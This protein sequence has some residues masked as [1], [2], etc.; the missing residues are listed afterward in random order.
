M[1]ETPGVH[2][3][4][5]RTED[6]DI[7][8]LSREALD[9]LPFGVITL[10]RSGTIL[11]YN[12]EQERLAH[13][14]SVPSVGLNFF[15][16]VAPCTNVQAFRGRFDAFVQ[17][18][19]AG[20]ERF[21][22]T[23]AFRWGHQ[24]VSITM[25][26]KAGVEEINILVRGR[27]T[28]AV[29]GTDGERLTD[30]D[31]AVAFADTPRILA[32]FGDPKTLP[33]PRTYGL[34]PL[35]AADPQSLG[36]RVHP[37]HVA[38]VG[39]V[40]AHAV[41]DRVPYAVEYRGS[42]GSSRR[43]FQEHGYFGP[44]PGQ[45]GQATIVDVTEQRQFA[46]DVWRA[47][48]YDP[49]TGLPNHKLLLLRI[50]DAV[51]AAAVDGRITAIILV[52]IVD[53]RSVNDTFGHVGGNKLLRAVGLRLGE[54]VR[55]G[56]TVARVTAD[57]FAVLLTD[58]AAPQSVTDVATRM[59]AAA[60]QPFEIDG[61]SHYLTLR[62]GVS[63][64]P[65]DGHDP[66]GLLIAAETAIYA[67]KASGGSE[68]RFYSKQLALDAASSLELQNE[69]RDGLE[70]RQFELAYQ[71]LVDI[72]TGRVVAVE[73]LVRWNHPARG[74]VSPLDFIPLADRSGLI[75]PLG[76]WVLRTACGQAR[77]WA[78]LGIDVRVCVN[79]STVQFARPDFVDL[80]ATV[81]A[82]SSLPAERLE[83]ELTESIMVDGFGEMVETLTRLK[84]LGL[85]LA[86]D[87]F[88]TGYS[89]LSYLKYFPVDTLKID[90]AF[91]KDIVADGFDNA[92]AT[93]I[94]TLS[95][96]LALECVVEGVETA[97]QLEAL[98]AIGCRVVQGFYFS[99][100]LTAAKITARFFGPSGSPLTVV[101]ASIAAT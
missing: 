59:I 74:F 14:H 17:S 49:L 4:D 7:F 8:E 24:D 16:D 93:T 44:Q 80:V 21:T 37:D 84:A 69:L 70:N 86:I 71:P 20:S 79:V 38:A 100:P 5:V 26:R 87:D 99:R 62:A 76:E 13:R 42:A 11:R 15:N 29:P 97:E 54:C 41:R 52:N 63:L 47:A 82:D 18:Y 73:A 75:V 39:L 94:F 55:G 83:L 1:M 67:A 66:Q 23:F 78:D 12:L 34:D 56:D 101:G 58:V 53:F 45:A 10:D 61:R 91:I 88:G 31:G 81:L 32:A 6:R 72:E 40:I 27:S 35:T 50:E 30:A 43:I 25:L 9:A 48:H 98:R 85:R 28:A 46:A 60:A 90:R 33:P 3:L 77:A 68:L 92:I 89:S 36:E 95:Q 64:A 65:Y 96:L 57:Q 2:L 51:R 22:F 19:E